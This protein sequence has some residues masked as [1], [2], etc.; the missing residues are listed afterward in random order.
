MSGGFNVGGLISGLDTNAIIEQLILLDRRPLIRLEEQVL[1]LEAQKESIKELRTE[2]LNLRNLIKDLQFGL[3]FNQFE[4]LSSTDTVLT[5]T[6]SGPNPTVG[7]FQIEV[8]QL[9]SSTI[10]TSS[11]EIG[12]AI[13]P[14]AALS[15]SGISKG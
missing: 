4:A 2:L 14:G 13:D 6:L 10:T 9:A 11:T 15:S 1:L 3:K 12:V 5:G 8:L 7:T